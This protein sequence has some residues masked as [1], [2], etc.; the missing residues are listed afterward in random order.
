[1]SE[2]VEEFVE[3]IEVPKK[4]FKD[5]IKSGWNK[6]KKGV[7]DGVEWVAEHPKE[8]AIYAGLFTGGC[9]MLRRGFR[10]ADRY[11]TA[12]REQYNKERFVY[13]HSAGRYLKTNRVLRND[14]VRRINE[15]RR[16]NP[17]M[18]MSEALDRL[19]LLE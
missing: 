4:G 9:A 18:K 15:L 8:A 3:K 16:R 2:T 5:K 1:M 14:D 13:D 7:S 12:R 10:S 19:N 17:D 6:V 11:I